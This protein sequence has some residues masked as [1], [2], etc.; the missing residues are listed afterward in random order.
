MVAIEPR[1]TKRRRKGV[2]KHCPFENEIAEGVFGRKQ[3]T[4]GTGPG[5]DG[6]SLQRRRH[7]AKPT[8]RPNTEHIVT[9]RSLTHTRCPVTKYLTARWQ[10]EA[11]FAKARKA[12]LFAIVPIHKRAETHEQMPEKKE[13]IGCNFNFQSTSAFHS[14]ALASS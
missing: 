6:V 10:R 5:P 1:A 12:L 13:P 9:P 8:Q 7:H 11:K 4:R 2:G 3:A 14:A